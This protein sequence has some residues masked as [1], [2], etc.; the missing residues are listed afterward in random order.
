MSTMQLSRVG[1]TRIAV[2]AA[3]ICVPL[4]LSPSGHRPAGADPLEDL[5]LKLA[6]K[7]AFGLDPYLGVLPITITV[8]EGSVT[9][10]GHVDLAMQK[11]LAMRRIGEIVDSSDVIDRLGIGLGE[12]AEIPAE[13]V[14]ANALKD[15]KLALAVR[16]KLKEGSGITVRD[17]RVVASDGAVTL[18]GKVNT[19]TDRG[20]A[21]RLAGEVDGV[22]HVTNNLKLPGEG[23]S[24]YREALP[25][26]SWKGRLHDTITVVR[27]RR[28]LARDSEL[29]PYRIRVEVRDGIV[30]LKGEVPDEDKV[31]LAEQ[32]ISDL[33]GTAGVVNELRVTE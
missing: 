29:A 19:P 31:L 26:R 33:T 13:R 17:L 21:G 11:R 10:S 7:T 2:A 15:A 12:P 16:R 1:F 8:E 18:D 14:D 20:K 6:L 9:V 4:F 25:D 22:L 3:L 27:A 32:L 24:S 28:V 30:T 5:R 23:S